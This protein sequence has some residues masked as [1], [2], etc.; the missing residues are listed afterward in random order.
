MLD[1]THRDLEH[2][3]KLD[4]CPPREHAEYAT[5]CC[6]N[7]NAVLE[8]RSYRCP[9]NKPSVLT[10]QSQWRTPFLESADGRQHVF[11][12]YGDIGI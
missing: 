4:L 10:F 2:L 11:V 5:E 8:L 3:E 12:E 6:E 1:N 7:D 9:L